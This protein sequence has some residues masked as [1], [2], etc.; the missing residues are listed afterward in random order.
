MGEHQITP[1][2]FG[3]RAPKQIEILTPTYIHTT[4]HIHCHFSKLVY[5][6]NPNHYGAIAIF[7]KGLLPF[8]WSKCSALSFNLASQSAE[9]LMSSSGAGK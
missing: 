1:H 4:I 3:S 8:G 6:A 2:S 5:L 7:M 9:V